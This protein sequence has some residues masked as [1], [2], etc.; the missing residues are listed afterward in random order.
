MNLGYRILFWSMTIALGFVNPLISFGLIILYYLPEIAGS[1]CK[2][3]SEAQNTTNY[4]ENEPNS[5]NSKYYSDDT[6]EAMK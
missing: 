2:A 5:S 3:C 1:V 4:D 6:L